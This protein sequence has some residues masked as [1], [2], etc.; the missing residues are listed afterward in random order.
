MSREFFGA[1][2]GG[3]ESYTGRDMLSTHKGMNIS[4]QEFIEVVDDILGAME[5]NKLGE[6]EIA[7]LKIIIQFG[8]QDEYAMTYDEITNKYVGASND[9]S[10]NADIPLAKLLSR[11]FIKIEPGKIKA[12]SITTAGWEWLV[13]SNNFTK[14]G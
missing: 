9:A 3:P 2:S 7:I 6:D 1:G 12:C 8:K 4:E 13:K 11:F 14:S 5:K 10:V